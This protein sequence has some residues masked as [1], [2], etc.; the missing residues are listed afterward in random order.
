[1]KHHLAAIVICVSTFAVLA[2]QPKVSNTHFNIEPT[3]GNLTATVDRFRHS[4]EQLW[5]G[6]EVPALPQSHLPAC[7][8]GSDTSQ[9][10]DGCCGEFQLEDNNYSMNRGGNAP[11]AQNIYVLFRFD[12]G[13]L[14]KVRP[15][16]AG[17]HLNAGGVAFTWLTG[18]QPGRECLLSRATRHA[19]SRI[20]SLNESSTERSCRLVI[21]QPQRLRIRSPK[22]HRLPPP[23]IR[24][25]KLPSGSE[26][27]ADTRAFL[28]CN[29]WKI[30]APTQR[31]ERSLPSISRRTPIPLRKTSCSTWP[32][33]TQTL[34]YVSRRF[35][36]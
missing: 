6:Y 24:G 34:R 21:M 13:Q 22:S 33:P 9:M 5:L 36:G 23:C 32:S 31:S 27:N 29:L 8:N 2:Q 12:H 18:V 26:C 3:G 10:D 20:E 15:V 30:K 11:A 35:S 28:P 19:R 16:I 7:S 4:S 17:C 1:M 25:S 14:I